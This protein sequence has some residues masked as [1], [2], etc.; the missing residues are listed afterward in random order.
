LKPKDPEK[1]E[2]VEV[3]RYALVQD[4]NPSSH[5]Q[6]KDYFR[7]MNYPIP[8]D[9]A[10]K[11]PTS[12]EE[13]VLKL[14]EKH[15]EDPVLPLIWEAGKSQKNGSYLAETYLGKDGR[16][17]TEFTYLPD[18]GRLSSRRPNLQNIPAGKMGTSWEADLAKAIRSTMI[19]SPGMIFLEADWRGIEAALVAFFASDPD[20]ARICAIDAHSYLTSFHVGA[21][22]DLGWADEALIQFLKEIKKKYPQEREIC[23]RANHSD[24]YGIGLGHLA[25]VLGTT[26]AGAQ[27]MKDLRDKAFPKVA[28]WKKDVRR[29][30]HLSGRLTNPFGYSRGFFEV[31]RPKYDRQSGKPLFDEKG[32][33]IMVEGRE[34]NQALAFLPQS[35]AAAMMR[36]TL[37]RLG[38][39]PM[40]GVLF[41]LLITIHDSILVECY[42]ENAAK[43]RAILKSEMEISW[44]ELNGLKVE[45]DLKEGTNWGEML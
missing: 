12:G 10:T 1:W 16:F 19:P 15:P 34:A 13:A 9:R 17:H 23:K 30:A 37:V 38:N 11:K 39:H 26:K 31:Y 29:L 2:L 40:H 25:E 24:G 27:E 36:D 8:K 22:A 43:V 42:P 33:A 3:L 44:V 5:Q 35:T 7:F 20:Y 28:Q 45:V 21:P 41:W 4:F 14:M 6:V 18:T 32:N